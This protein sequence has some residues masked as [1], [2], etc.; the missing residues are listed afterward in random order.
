MGK[1]LQVSRVVERGNPRS[2]SWNHRGF[3]PV[4]MSIGLSDD[5]E[6]GELEASENVNNLPWWEKVSHSDPGVR[7][8]GR[9][10]EQQEREKDVRYG[11]D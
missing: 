10:E 6:D 5:D 3:S 11:K 9:K 4:R 1:L 8:Q 7:Q 2:D